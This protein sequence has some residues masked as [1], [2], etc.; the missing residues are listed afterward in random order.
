M[1][2]SQHKEVRHK[3]P[4]CGQIKTFPLRQGACGGKCSQELQRVKRILRDGKKP[5]SLDQ[6]AKERLLERKVRELR[7]KLNKALDDGHERSEF[8]NLMNRALCRPVV[9]PSWTQKF[10]AKRGKVHRVMAKTKCSDWHLG[11][12]IRPQ[13]VRWLNGYNPAIADRRL[14]RYFERVLRLSFDYVKGFEYTGVVVSMLGDMVSGDIHEELR[15]TNSLPTMTTVLRYVPRVAAGLKLFAHHFKKVWVVVTVGNHGRDREKI[16][17]KGRVERNYDWLFG[18]LLA[19]HL[20]DDKRIAFA[21]SPAH[22]FKYR[23][24]ATTYLA[25]H[26]D[27]AKGGSGIAAMY[28]PLMLAAHRKRRVDR[29]WSYWECGHW[30]QRSDWADVEVNG[31]GKG[32]DEYAMGKSFGHQWPEQDFSIIDPQYGKICHWPVRVMDLNESWVKHCPIPVPGHFVGD[33]PMAP[34]DQPYQLPA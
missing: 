6:L 12:E 23:I 28:S 20:A 25:S 16:I 33:V 14:E 10:P 9:I 4:I 19:D 1:A 15:M 18:Q 31:S 7:S 27:E 22:Q 13:E 30:H 5:K 8:D 32:Y 21:I 34:L 29:D 11:E 26:G 2:T 24:H 17:F 3:C